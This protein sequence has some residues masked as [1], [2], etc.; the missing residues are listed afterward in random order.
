MITI[1]ALCLFYQS[2]VLMSPIPITTKNILLAINL[3]IMGLAFIGT[4][5]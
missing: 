1:I 3:V 2:I 5:I 4:L